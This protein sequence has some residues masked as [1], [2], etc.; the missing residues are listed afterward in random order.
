[1]AESA[2]PARTRVVILGGGFGGAYSAMYL[3]KLLPPE[4]IDLT[5]VS[6][7][8]FL[9]FT[10]MLHEVAASDID[11]TH[12][13]SPL[14]QLIRRGVLFNGEVV[15]IDLAQRRVT[16]EHA[17]GGHHHT[18]DYDHLVLALGSVTNFFG[19][20]GVAERALTMKS[21]TD[22]TE[23]RSRAID[24]LEQAD[25]EAA[26]GHRQPLLT[27]VVA[28]GGFAG[29]ETIGALN[30][31]VRDALREYRHLTER[32]VRMVLVHPGD[33]LLPELGPGLGA[34][35]ATA[36]AKRG[37]EVRLNTSV[38][39]ADAAGVH[40]SDGTTIPMA[41]LIWTAGTAPNPILRSLPVADGKGRIP[42]D[43]TL[44]V[45]G[46]RGLW[47]LGDA[48]VVPDPQGKPYPPTAQH[49]IRQARVLA[50]NI[51]AAIRSG[52][53]AGKSRRFVYSS[54]G[55]LAA[56]GRRTGVASIMGH[57]FTGFVA[58]FLWRGIYLGKLPRL[59]RKV[60]VAID[61][62]LD[63]VLPKDLVRIRGP[64]PRLPDGASAG[65]APIAT[66]S[67]PPRSAGPLAPA[68]SWSPGLPP[69]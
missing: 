37:V 54:V 34:F 15:G 47:A 46:A 69:R 13:V 28:G 59:D 1:M 16:V 10:P 53:G 68:S 62:L 20:P 50:M 27:F 6:R 64:E 11:V 21:L 5:L 66:T 7:E 35:A 57:N 58:W 67:V 44:A 8:N 9:L 30:D 3:E 41:T 22:A 43:A 65:G 25:F 36:I 14:R 18:L 17:S 2:Q 60:R 38:Q 39:A 40:L 4:D 26:S 24:L 23:V 29:V 33:R 31:F 48:A 63:L 52:T 56:I 49:A 61:W 45:A 32:E 55:Q 19:L 12:I 51:A 42:V